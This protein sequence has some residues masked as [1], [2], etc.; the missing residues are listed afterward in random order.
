[1]PRINEFG[2]VLSG[3]AGAVSVDGRILAPRGT[4]AQWWNKYFA[5]Y[6]RRV[7]EVPFEVWDLTI[8]DVRD[9]AMTQLSPFNADFLAAWQGNW[10]AWNGVI[11]LFGSVEPSTLAGIAPTETDNR[12]AIAKNG[13][14]GLK[15]SYQS[16]GPIELVPPWR[17]LGDSLN[18]RINPSP[19]GLFI[20]NEFQAVWNGGGSVGFASPPT[21][22]PG[23][24]NI[25]WAASGSGTDWWAYWVDGLG[26]VAHRTGA[27][28]NGYLLSRD[29]AF[30]HDIVTSE[31][32]RL[33]ACWSTDS[34][35]SPNGYRKVDVWTLPIV[36]LVDLLTKP[37]PP[38]DR[39]MWMIWF[40]H[41]VPPARPPGNGVIN[42]SDLIVR[43]FDGTP[44]ASY[45][46]PEAEGNTI[47]AYSRAL[48]KARALNPNLPVV[49]YW[50][51][52]LHGPDGFI[53]PGDIIAPEAYV[54]AGEPLDVADRRIRTLVRRLQRVAL[55][56][57]CYDTNASLT[58]DLDSLIPMYARICHEELNIGMGMAFSDWG[59]NIPNSNPPRGGLQVHPELRPRW[60]QFSSTI[61]TPPVPPPPLPPEDDVQVPKV[62]IKDPIPPFSADGFELKVH[63]PN[64]DQDVIVTTKNGSWFVEWKTPAGSDKS[65]KPRPVIIKG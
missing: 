58:T 44:I 64:N 14:I 42:A 39:T 21:F 40:E 16:T 18:V 61:R 6:Q 48:I 60:T 47:E 26:L 4:C 23:A 54:L 59:R 13:T 32:G 45:I 1:M 8:Q 11:G 15:E 46:A 29:D 53:P 55:V 31:T 50:P 62:S 25:R 43:T 30:H 33:L 9:G 5:V 20:L 65:V 35:E 38:V 22:L 49:S 51:R 37:I 63:D 28:P 24:R 12:G 19:Y 10:A 56:M 57:Q 27:L 2:W 36:N 7:Q 52:Q 41:A 34:G 17:K 3:K